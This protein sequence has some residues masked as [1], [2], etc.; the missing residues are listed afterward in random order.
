M[1]IIILQGNV[2]EDPRIKDFE[3]GGKVA[4]FSLATTEKGF[5]TQD[6]KEVPDETTWHNIVV[7]K[8]GLAGV[9]QQFVKKGSPLLVKGRITNRQ[10]LDAQG[11]TRYIT[12]V[13]VD[14]LTLL[15]KKEREQAPAPT[16]DYVPSRPAQEPGGKLGGAPYYPPRPQAQP[17]MPQYGGPQYQDDGDMPLFDKNGNFQG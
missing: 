4:Q 8:S 17:P 1:N 14:D 13:V 7:K 2:G 10:Y 15:G 5:K 3:S 6:G 9:V 16:P 12:E 11:V